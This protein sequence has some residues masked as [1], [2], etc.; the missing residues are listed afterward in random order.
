MKRKIQ[1]YIRTWEKRGYP[2]GIPDEA[3]SRLEELG[4]VPSYRLI[5][6]AIM[7][8]DKNLEMLGFTRKP[9]DLYMKLKRQELLLKGKIKWEP[10]QRKLF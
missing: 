2:N 9:C 3:P 8:N 4:K 1:Q 7:K 10:V 5:C 6:I